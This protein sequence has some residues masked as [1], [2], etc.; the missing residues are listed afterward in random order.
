MTFLHL[1]RW[2]NLAIVIL[3]QYLLRHS[4]LY[5]S[6]KGSGV[7][8]GFS[9]WQFAA[10]VLATVL[11]AAAGYLINDI[12]DYQ[13]DLVNKPDKVIVGKKLSIAAAWRLYIGI[14]LIALVLVAGLAW[15]LHLYHLLWFF[16]FI[17]LLLWLYS[18]KLKRMAIWGNLAVALFCSAVVLLV[19][20]V[21]TESYQQF[22]VRSATQASL[23]TG[24]LVFYACFAF[25]STLYR[26]VV[27]DIQDMEGDAR[28]GCRTLPIV[29]GY[30]GAKALSLALG[31]SVAGFIVAWYAWAWP[32]LSR[33]SVAYTFALL[34]IPSLYSVY[35]L[36]QAHA[37][38]AYGK[39][40]KQIKL[41]MLF[42]LLYLPV[43][44]YLP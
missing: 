42:G 33:W 31:A 40:S 35:L 3:T 32:Q 29:W 8:L 41:L 15:Q 16:P 26:E 28:Y 36:T 11:S 10:L 23:T 13:I 6:Y 12:Y 17:W 22:Q 14:H 2:P 20:W 25:L 21:E 4:V 18:Y 27:K 38:A 9:E 37:L 39:V 1:F 19:W 30:E 7:S 24:V 5:L 44:F 34:L 43:V